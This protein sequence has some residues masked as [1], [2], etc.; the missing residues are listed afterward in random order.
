MIRIIV[1]HNNKKGIGFKNGIPWKI[2]KDL[3]RF[4]R[5]T[6]GDNMNSVIMG[7]KTWESLPN[8][9]PLPNRTNIIISNTLCKSNEIKYGIKIFNRIEDANSY[10]KAMDYSENWV[11]GGSD[12]YRAYIN[13][14]IVEQIYITNVNIDCVCDT[15]FPIIEN[16]ILQEKGIPMND[17]GLTY[18]Y[19]IFKNRS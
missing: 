18:T 2:G 11:I 14:N 5:L 12:I 15:F 17:G 9:G 7:R 8:Q 10:C 16:Y 6:V 1:A 4:K 19:D 13:M 3:T